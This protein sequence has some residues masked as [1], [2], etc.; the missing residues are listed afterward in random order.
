VST[1]L[2]GALISVTISWSDGTTTTLQ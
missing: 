1:T 2:V